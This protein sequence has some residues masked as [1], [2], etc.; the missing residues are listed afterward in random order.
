MG[1][2]NFRI[3]REDIAIFQREAYRYRPIIQTLAF[4]TFDA[5]ALVPLICRQSHRANRAPRAGYY[6][7][8]KISAALN[9]IDGTGFITARRKAM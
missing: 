2:V 5:D 4:V 8:R 9:Q 3:K 7:L 6:S 1:R